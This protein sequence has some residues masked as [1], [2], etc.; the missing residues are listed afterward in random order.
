MHDIKQFCGLQPAWILGPDIGVDISEAYGYAMDI[1]LLC[2]D[3]LLL[4]QLRTVDVG[5]KCMKQ[6]ICSY[7]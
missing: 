3:N 4:V 2:V 1:L 5:P 7:K 6:R